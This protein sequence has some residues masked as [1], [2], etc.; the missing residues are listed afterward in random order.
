MLGEIVYVRY[1]ITS[2][3]LVI[4]TVVTFHICCVLTKFVKDVPIC[5]V[6]CIVHIFR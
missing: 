6:V 1:D 2:I 4:F 5:Y 3:V